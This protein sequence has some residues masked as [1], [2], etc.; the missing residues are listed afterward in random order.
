MKSKI[1]GIIMLVTMLASANTKLG[2]FD[3]NEAADSIINP[4]RLHNIV[5]IAGA[6]IYDCIPT[7]TYGDNAEGYEGHGFL[8]K[9]NEVLFYCLERGAKK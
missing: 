8:A 5:L 9:I 2:Y 1:I 7:R 4:D 3:P 6:T